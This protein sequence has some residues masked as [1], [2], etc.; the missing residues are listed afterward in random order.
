MQFKFHHLKNEIIDL[1]RPDPVPIISLRTLRPLNRG[2]KWLLSGLRYIYLIGQ[3]VERKN[4]QERTCTLRRP[5]K[6]G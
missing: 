5:S 4:I 3:V 2:H 1:G 6:A